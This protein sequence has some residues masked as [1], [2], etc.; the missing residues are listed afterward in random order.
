MATFTVQKTSKHSAHIVV[1]HNG[2]FSGLK[3]QLPIYSVSGQVWG[4]PTAHESAK[5]LALALNKV[6]KSRNW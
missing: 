4:G 6:I 5:R 1:K 3:V 2:G